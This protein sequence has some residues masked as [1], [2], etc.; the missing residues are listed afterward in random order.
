MCIPCEWVLLE[1]NN[2]SSVVWCWMEQ[3]N[4]LGQVLLNLQIWKFSLLSVG[5]FVTQES[6]AEKMLWGNNIHS[7]CELCTIR[8]YIPYLSCIVGRI[9]CLPKDAHI[10]IS[11]TWEKFTLH[12]KWTLQL[13]NRE[14]GRLYRFIQWDTQCNHKSPYKWRGSHEG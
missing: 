3:R 13:S 10:L 9:I 5:L 2:V 6:I 7:G 8:E 4:C 1:V 12:G 11:A 14:V